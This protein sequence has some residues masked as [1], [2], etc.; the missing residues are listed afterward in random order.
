VNWSVSPAEWASI[1]TGGI[2]TGISAGRVIVTAAAADESGTIDT[3]RVNIVFYYVDSILVATADDSDTL[4]VDD[5][6]QMNA[7]VFPANAS[8]S[9]I[10]WSVTPGTLAE[11]SESGLLTAMATGDVT[12]TATSTDGS[13]VTGLKEVFIKTTVGMD[14]QLQHPNIGVYPNPA[15]GG[16]F[17]INTPKDLTRIEVMNL[18]GEKIFEID[19]L[20]QGF[21]EIQLDVTPGIY[22]IRFYAG[23]QT[24]YEKLSVE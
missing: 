14:D 2:L 18:H 16:K 17:T 5:Q 20:K 22:L 19:E 4:D 9:G 1:T 7:T 6:L 23:K 24:F 21:H 8:E 11:I 15:P 13:G 3:M 12:I 10:T